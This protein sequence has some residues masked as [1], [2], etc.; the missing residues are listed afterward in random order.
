MRCW[1]FFLIIVALYGVGLAKECPDTAPEQ[2]SECDENDICTACGD[3]YYLTADKN[4]A[5]CPSDLGCSTCSLNKDGAVEC[6]TCKPESFRND[7][8]ECKPCSG[9]ENEE[10]CKNCKLGSYLELANGDCY[11]C[12]GNND[13]ADCKIPGTYEEGDKCKMCEDSNED[14]AAC[15]L[16][17]MYKDGEVCKYCAE[18]D[19][20][21]EHCVVGQYYR[22][23]TDGICFKCPEGNDCAVCDGNGY[24]KVGDEGSQWCLKCAEGCSTCT[25]DQVI[26]C[27]GCA[28]GYYNK[29]ADLGVFDC[30]K[31]V[32]ENGCDSKQRCKEEEPNTFYANRQCTY[33]TTGCAA[34]HDA[35]SCA[36]CADNYFRGTDD[37]CSECTGDDLENNKC[38]C[39][40]EKGYYTASNGECRKC[41]AGCAA[42]EDAESCTKCADNYYRGND[43][44][45]YECTG[46]DLENNKC[47]CDAEEGYYTANGECKKCDPACATC[48]A[49]GAKNCQLCNPDYYMTGD[50]C[51][52]CSGEDETECKKCGKGYFNNGKNC[53]KCGA[54]N[55]KCKTCG[56]G[57]YTK[58]DL[59]YEC[60]YNLQ[61]VTC[62]DAESCNSCND[63]YYL[64]GGSCK[65]CDDACATCTGAG[66]GDKCVTCVQDKVINPLFDPAD[67]NSEKCIGSCPA[68][69]FQDGQS[70]VKTCPEGKYA[71]DGKCKPCDSAC[72]TCTGAEN[73]DKCLTCVEGKVINPLFNPEA[74]DSYK[75]IDSCPESTESEKW[76]TYGQNC[77]KD[78]CPDGAYAD[79]TL[80]VC[81]KCTL[82]N[83]VKCSSADKCDACADGFVR[84][85]AG[86]CEKAPEQ[87]VPS[88]AEA[89]RNW[90][91]VVVMACL[92]VI[93]ALI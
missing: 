79:D 36:K 29:E 54:S 5:P 84:T 30:Q 88:G 60:N 72:A 47:K 53:F 42:C 75:C 83:C 58:D 76:Y 81:H 37:K 70:C 35:E 7:K 27:T 15:N 49:G 50:G 63:K 8:G 78:K 64:E 48:D 26:A 85:D 2:C 14:C 43:D 17:D 3:A 93:A 24:S 19:G 44:K 69:Y 91:C 66:N 41:P 51:V 12:G 39:D 62:S 71:E 73:K 52:H 67:A 18:L 61:C 23:E 89:K 90:T 45:C 1:L 55:E 20:D 34:C 32:G 74:D 25:S 82:A 86:A 46:D 57:Y 77:E 11:D 56:D 28:E 92:M 80:M 31:C 59:C 4:C 68:E 6:L 33:C 22:L 40:A 10:D 13:C 38:K 21:C 9:A 16:Q 65:Q 87:N